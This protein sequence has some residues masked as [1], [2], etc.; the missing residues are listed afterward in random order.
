MKKLFY[1]LTLFLVISCSDSETVVD[2]T[3][4]DL[5]GTWNLTKYE[6][7]IILKI[8]YGIINA[9][10]D[11]QIYGKNFDFTL[12][13]TDTPNEFITN[14]EFISVVEYNDGTGNVEN[15]DY[16]TSSIDDINSGNWNLEDNILTISSDNKYLDLVIDSYSENKMVLKHS[17]NETYTDDGASFEA[18]TNY[19]IVLER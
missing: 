17:L 14:G 16:E 9:E 13:F 4:V 11:T 19:L 2:I 7:D 5:L 12:S 10:T 1:L 15:Y 6:Q 3:E 8:D 18:K